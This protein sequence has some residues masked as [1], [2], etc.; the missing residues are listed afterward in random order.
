VLFSPFKI[1]KQA[2]VI[3]ARPI[4]A[5][6]APPNARKIRRSGDSPGYF[7]SGALGVGGVAGGAGVAGAEGVAG[8]AGALGALGALGA[9]GVSEVD[10]GA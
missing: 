6:L 10:G 2:A 7:C 8:V 1:S 4:S 9:V 3:V 5:G